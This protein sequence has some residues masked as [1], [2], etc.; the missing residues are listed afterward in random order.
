MDTKGRKPASS[1]QLPAS[2]VSK[3]E[4]SQGTSSSTGCDPSGSRAPGKGDASAVMLTVGSSQKSGS[5]EHVAQIHR[6]GQA[7][8]T[9]LTSYSSEPKLHKSPNSSRPQTSTDSPKN[10]HARNSV[11]TTFRI[12]AK[13][14]PKTQHSRASAASHIPAKDSPK[15]NSSASTSQTAAKD[16]KNQNKLASSHIPVKVSP[17]INKVPSKTSMKESPSNSSTP[18][19]LSDDL[20]PVSD[21]GSLAQALRADVIPVTSP[22]VV[23]QQVKQETK[24]TSP[25]VQ[26]SQKPPK[27]EGKRVP[28]PRTH[29]KD[30]HSP[31]PQQ[32]DTH[33]HTQKQMTHTVEAQHKAP[34]TTKTQH[35]SLSSQ[36]THALT[37]ASQHSATPKTKRQTSPHV[38]ERKTV[39]PRDKSA[40]KKGKENDGKGVRGKDVGKSVATMT[41]PEGLGKDVAVQVS[42]DLCN[43]VT[44]TVSQLDNHLTG[45]TGGHINAEESALV[46]RPQKPIVRQR[47]SSQYVCQIEIELS[48]QSP[49]TSG[50][51]P[52]PATAV[53]PALPS[54]SGKSTDGPDMP[55]DQSEAKDKTGEGL[56]Q[57]K[58]G[59]VQEVTW[60]D[61]GLTW[62]V[63]GATLDWQALGSA[64]QRH[65]H[66]QI[67][68]LELRLRTLQ[69]S[70]SEKKSP[71]HARRVRRKCRCWF[72]CSSCCCKRKQHSA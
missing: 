52:P 19:S 66:T 48:S 29:H 12:P 72:H 5:M 53:I 58:A 57:E 23:H 67:E 63:Y 64:V 36:P 13:D 50:Q 31:Q 2:R 6:S 9:H 20:S 46:L 7:G 68:Q 27:E 28:S 37:A 35:T 30:A 4:P 1:P 10:P 33:T 42:D 43:D 32:K 56:R 16:P 39:A 60:D 17:K 45:A 38:T 40:E 54:L 41:G 24:Q 71:P 55:L 11:V 51:A 15:L 47:P 70:V 21:D 59:P 49:K 26:D 18:L 25:V 62:E 69:G 61:Q 65:L 34:H 8:K 44:V 22:P 14:S 3:Q